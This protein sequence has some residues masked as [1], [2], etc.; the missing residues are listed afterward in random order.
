LKERLA[1]YV[2]EA[3]GELGLCELTEKVGMQRQ[4][5]GGGRTVEVMP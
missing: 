4:V 2:R 5:A 1:P 3:G